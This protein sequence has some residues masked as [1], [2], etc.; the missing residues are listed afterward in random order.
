MRWYVSSPYKIS[1]STTEADANQV[2]NQLTRVIHFCTATEKGY[3]L[4]VTHRLTYALVM[5]MQA[6]ATGGKHLLGA[7]A[8]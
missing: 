1:R 4:V 7:R 3:A 6:H 8:S 2:R 5:Y